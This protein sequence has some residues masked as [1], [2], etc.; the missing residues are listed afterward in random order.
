V[1]YFIRKPGLSKDHGKVSLE[2]S[3]VKCPLSP[4]PSYQ[5]RWTSMDTIACLGETLPVPRCDVGEL[6]SNAPRISMKATCIRWGNE[7]RGGAWSRPG[8]P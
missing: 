5:T 6:D 1:P 4:P 3:L 7:N 2:P 8:S